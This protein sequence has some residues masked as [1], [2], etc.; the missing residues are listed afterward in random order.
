MN[1]RSSV[2]CSATKTIFLLNKDKTMCLKPN[3]EI[4]SRT[5]AKYLQQA[6]VPNQRESYLLKLT[7]KDFALPDVARWRQSLRCVS[8]C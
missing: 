2:A 5:Q 7:G 1:H 4:Q 6:L 3:E 8:R